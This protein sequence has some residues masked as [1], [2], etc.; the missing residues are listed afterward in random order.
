MPYGPCYSHHQRV[1]TATFDNYCEK[2]CL[3]QSKISP[4]DRGRKFTQVNRADCSSINFPP[5]H[6]SM[7]KVTFCCQFAYGKFRNTRA[8]CIYLSGLDLGSK[9]T[10]P[11]T[12]LNTLQIYA[13]GVFHNKS[14]ISLTSTAN[15]TGGTCPFQRNQIIFYNFRFEWHDNFQM[16]YHND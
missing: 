11:W 6:W 14:G 1:F 4:K 2:K 5:D 13:C 8:T 7:A 3:N 10:I 12:L 9:L 15:L 16:L